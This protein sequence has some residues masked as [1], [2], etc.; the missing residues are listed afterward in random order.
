ME[1]LAVGTRWDTAGVP[2]PPDRPPAD[3]PSFGAEVA[4]CGDL[5]VD[6]ERDFVEVDVAD[7]AGEARWL[8]AMGARYDR[9]LADTYLRGAAE[10]AA[11]C[12]EPGEA[13]RREWGARAMVAELA[14]ALHV[15]EVTLAHRLMRITMLAAFPR[16]VAAA[17]AGRVSSWHC[18]VVLDVFAGITDPAALAAADAALIDRALVATAPQLRTSARRWRSRH[19]PPTP[20]ERT[21]HL[22]D[23]HV[24]V[25]P[26]DQDMVWLTA[27]IPV[28]AGMA[29]DERLS[30]LAAVSDGAGDGRTKAQIRADALVDLLL[31]PGTAPDLTASADASATD[32]AEVIAACEDSSCDDEG[33]RGRPAM[34]TWVRG[35]RPDLV[36]TVPV[37][38]LLGHSDEPAELEGFGPID[39]DTARTLAAQAPSFVR[40]LTDPETGAVLSVGRDRY[41]LP[42]DLKR[43]VQLRDQ[44]C[45][46]PGCRRRA[47]D[48]D[49]DHSTAWADGGGSDMC[50]LECLCRKH[51]RLKHAM[52]WTVTHRAGGVLDWTSPTGARYTTEPGALWPPPP[53][54]PWA[55]QPPSDPHPRVASAYPD[56]PP[57]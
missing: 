48:C 51:H 40:A 17:E 43:A 5:V 56:E 9:R 36:L 34:P 2:L 27:L 12:G 22:A 20:E 35:I 29:I 38:S 54:E 23:R 25:T 42:A 6:P 52:G 18:D 13:R 11:R 44:T 47:R 14:V 15:P 50:N 1:L 3:R 46:F 24:R 57:F 30:Q 49:V 19:L 45:R 26:A 7:R 37:L 39:L 41:R 4:W 33:G 10:L 8:A 28:A 21:A 32:A 31:S 53:P 16:F 55:C